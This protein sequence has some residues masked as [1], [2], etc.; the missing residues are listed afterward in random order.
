LPAG[1]GAN[2]PVFGNQISL[3]GSEL[4]S[5]TG[6]PGEPI[7]GKLFLTATRPMD[8]D[9]GLWVDLL[10][11]GTQVATWSAEPRG[12]QLP[13]SVWAAGEVI[14]QDF[15]LAVPANAPAGAYQ[16]TAGVFDRQTGA[17]LETGSGT[18]A[19]VRDV[20]IAPK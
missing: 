18:A 16:I 12:G 17:R 14:D 2:P 3:L 6:R 7:A 9:Y 13:T 10:H 1:R 15:S 8:H 5:P 11:A 19:L 4:P 20:E